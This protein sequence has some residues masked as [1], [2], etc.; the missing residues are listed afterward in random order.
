M[1]RS[2]NGRGGAANRSRRAGAGQRQRM[3]KK[4]L[5]LVGYALVAAIVFGAVYFIQMQSDLRFGADVFYTGTYVNGVPLEGKTYDQAVAEMETLSQTMLAGTSIRLT[6]GERSWSLVPADIGARLDCTEAI[7]QAWSYAREGSK[8][9]RRAQIRALRSNPIMLASSLTY[10]EQALESFVYAIKSEIDTEPVSATVT[11]VGY[12]Q[13]Q[14][15]QSQTGVSLDADGLIA[16]LTDA[17]IMGGAYDFALEPAIAEPEH[18]TEELV[19]ATQLVARKST[20]T[21]NSSSDRTANIRLALSNFNGLCVPAGEQISFNA[22][23][24]ERNEARGYNNAMEYAGTSFTEG[25]GGGTCQ[26][27][28]TLYDAVLEA[29]LQIDA[30]SNHNMTVG[31]VKPSFDAAVNN[32][33]KDLVFTNNSGYPLYFFTHVTSE[34]ATVSIF[35]KPSEYQIVLRSKVIESDIPAKEIRYRKD[36]EGKYVWYDDELMLASEGKP[37]MRSEAFRDFVKDGQV[38]TTER[39][40]IDYY[41]PQ[42][43]IYWVGVHPRGEG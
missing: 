7:D 39:L 29:G 30:R 2:T 10:D 13:F 26:A 40:S 11:V 41:Q 6:Y 9:A 36:K 34:K 28:T 14:I 20:T 21:E 32:E 31:Y 22:I 33:T 18:T 38:V 1:Q 23:V 42:P 4:R 19:E 24:G 37:G 12:E 3:R 8:I 43:N 15:T 17:M 27:S 35:G 16:Q 5:A 25:F